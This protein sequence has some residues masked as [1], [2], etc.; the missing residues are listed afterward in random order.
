MSGQVLGF[1]RSEHQEAFELLPW[2]VNGTLEQAERVLVE[3]HVQGCA[4]CRRER[5]WL[6][7]LSGAYAQSELAVDGELAFRRLERQLLARDVRVR[8]GGSPRMRMRTG[9]LRGLFT[10]NAPWLKFALAMQIGV[11]VALA[12][13]F[14]VR[15]PP[16]FHVLGAT[17]MR[18]GSNIIVVFDPATRESELRRILREVGARVVDG[19][20]AANGY[21]LDV[22]GTTGAALAHLRAEP[23]VILAEPLQAESAR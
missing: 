16:R 8:A 17:P 13:A 15:E 19:P 3:Q 4:A 6:Q 11:I 14:A 2:F 23:V 9:R 22:A 21:V 1:V 12:W 20:T 5:D 7:R 18:A 10:A